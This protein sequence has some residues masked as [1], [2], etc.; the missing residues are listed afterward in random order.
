M[1]SNQNHLVWSRSWWL[2]AAGLFSFDLF[3]QQMSAIAQWYRNA[4]RCVGWVSLDVCLQPSKTQTPD[5][6]ANEKS[7]EMTTMGKGQCLNLG[8]PWLSRAAK[9][10]PLRSQR[11]FRMQVSP[12]SSTCSRY[13]IALEVSYRFVLVFY[14][15]EN[16]SLPVCL[17]VKGLNWW[18]VVLDWTIVRAF[19]PS[20]Y[21]LPSGNCGSFSVLVHV[22][23]AIEQI[24]P[25]FL[26]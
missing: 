20:L 18:N 2:S 24:C 1:P 9:L 17:G 22:G 10:K 5:S 15:I 13:F 21:D 26:K 25:F 8:R 16:I 14:T 11:F 7:E 12:W 4:L 3:I 19:V 23:G 6:S